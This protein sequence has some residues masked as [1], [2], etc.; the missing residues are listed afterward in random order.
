MK[1]NTNASNCYFDYKNVLTDQVSI[2]LIWRDRQLGGR[3]GVR[4]W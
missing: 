2:E 1:S 4:L 3:R